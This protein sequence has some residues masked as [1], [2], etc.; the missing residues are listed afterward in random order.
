MQ[1]LEKLMFSRDVGGPQRKY[2]S[3]VVSQN[4]AVP[5]LLV[6]E[7]CNFDENI[8]FVLALHPLTKDFVDLRDYLVEHLLSG[9]VELAFLEEFALLCGDFVVE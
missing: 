8:F 3:A 9:G 5:L 6:D 4:L 2:G 7:S 1:R